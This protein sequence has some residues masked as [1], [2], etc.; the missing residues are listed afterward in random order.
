MGARVKENPPKPGAGE[1]NLSKRG[2]GTGLQG[3]ATAR[4]T[5]TAAMS[6]LGSIAG[7]RKCLCFSSA[8]SESAQFVYARSHRQPLVL[9]GDA[10]GEA[11][12][13]ADPYVLYYP[14]TLSYPFL[15]VSFPS[16]AAIEVKPFATEEEAETFMAEKTGVVRSPVK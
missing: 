7:G 16:G 11:I 3:K 8:T 6:S 4:E 5:I 10:Y 15:V 9:F 12:S 14:P 1:V 13:M 2:A